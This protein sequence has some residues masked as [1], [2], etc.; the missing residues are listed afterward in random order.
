M[1]QAGKSRVRVP[2]RTM[3]FSQLTYSLQQHYGPGVDL[4]FNRNEYQESS[5]GLKG[6]RRVRLTT[7]PPSVSRLSRKCGSLDVSQPYG[8]P[9][10]VTGIALPFS[11]YLMYILFSILVHSL[12][13]S[14]LSAPQHFRFYSVLHS[15]LVSSLSLSLSLSVISICVLLFASQLLFNQYSSYCLSKISFPFVYL[16][17]S[18]DGLRFWFSLCIGNRMK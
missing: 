15:N 14:C 1:L 10:S 9:R 3:D 18:A 13:F 17:P 7:S 6:V 12:S 5:W 11:P 2:M 16:M 4:A 8:P